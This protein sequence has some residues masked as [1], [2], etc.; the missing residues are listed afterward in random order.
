MPGQTGAPSTAPDPTV[1]PAAHT[2]RRRRVIEAGAFV[3]VWVAAGY[4]LPVSSNGYLLLGIPLTIAFQVL[5]RRRPVHEL[6]AATATRFRVDGR[7][8]AIAVVLAVVP[9]Y[10]AA[11]ALAGHDWI[12]SGWYLAGAVGAIG[13]ALAMIRSRGERSTSSRARSNAVE[14]AGTLG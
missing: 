9:G 6:F 8:V 1:R 2:C 7:G 3:A 11:K 5:V 13:A 10:Y 4:L 12:T 14:R